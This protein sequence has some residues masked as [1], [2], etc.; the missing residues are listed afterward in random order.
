M[1]L[2]LVP[3]DLCGGDSYHLRYYKPNT[4]LRLNLYQFPVVQC[5]GCGLVYVNPRPTVAQMGAF[6]P[7]GY[8]AGR[9]A[10]AFIERYRRQGALLPPLAGRKV[11][12]IG[13]ARGDFLSF[14]L[15]RE[16][17]EAHG[18]DAYSGGVDDPRI[19]FRPT[20]LADAGY[21]D[22]MFDVVMAWAVFEHLH[23]PSDYF[24]EAT[25]LLAPGG[26]LMI[27]VTNADS[28]YGRGACMEDV[29]RHTYH[30]TEATLAAY[31]QKC[32]LRLD[33]VLFDDS[34][35]DGRGR[36]TF[37]LLFGRLT[38]FS[39]EKYMRREL[40][41]F[42]RLA[43]KAGTLL[44]LLVFLGHWEARLRRSGVMI[45]TYAKP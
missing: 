21:P 9:D 7:A 17:F 42:T 30:Y 40:H 2:E 35:F 4:W 31:G 38:G 29:P 34:I 44:D 6:Y 15:D 32:G 45:A 1:E 37:R 5:D 39:W 14:L 12:D 22:A 33:R 43:M 16:A 41:A 13:C 27:L 20:Q 23:R 19:H 24:A 25:R 10:E 8:H 18:V 36:G 3:C 26:Q 11:L 28:L